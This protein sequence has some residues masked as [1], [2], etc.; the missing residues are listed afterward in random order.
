MRIPRYWE[1]AVTEVTVPSGQN[2]EVTAWGWSETSIHE[3]RARA[4]ELLRRKVD[5]ARQGFPRP[6]PETRTDTGDYGGYPDGPPREEI[7]R[8]I[9]GSSDVAAL[10]TRNSYGSLVL[11]TRELMFI[12]VDLPP[13][14]IGQKL[15]MIIGRLFGRRAVRSPEEEALEQIAGALEQSGPRR[16]RIYRT[17]SGFRCAILDSPVDP[18]SRECHDLLAAVGSDPLYVRLCQRQEC[19][20]ARLTPKFWRCRAQRPPC[21]YPFPD[22]AAEAAYR[23]WEQEYERITADYATCRLIRE[24][25]HGSVYPN[26]AELIALHDELTGAETEQPLA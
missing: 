17:H 19:F 21:R 24:I 2:R 1:R 8:E 9:A 6:A 23:R 25:R 3:A 5:R 20:R 11:C 18:T 22:A 15:G 14:R 13:H 10:V 16:A 7:I 12:D 26:F 4:E